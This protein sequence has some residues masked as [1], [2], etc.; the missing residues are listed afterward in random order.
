VNEPAEKKTVRT[1]RYSTVDLLIMAVVAAIG[2]V[3][4]ALVINP[5]VRTLN[6][7]SPFLAMWPGSLHLL[8]IVLGGLL[9]RKPGAAMVTALM[10]GLLQML[11]GNTAGA[12]CLIYGVGNGVGAELGMALFRYKFKPAS[13]IIT[14]GLATATGFAVD[15]IYWFGNFAPQFKV[16]Y[17]VD[18][19]FAGSV[20]CGLVSLGIMQALKRAGVTR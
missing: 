6:L 13:A 5:L 3:V 18:A 17:I 19:F 4:S 9:V 12:L 20:V 11:F 16:L 10:N 15:L 2:A 1:Y 14:A 7:G 8:A